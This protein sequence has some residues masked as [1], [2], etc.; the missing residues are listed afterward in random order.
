MADLN[1]IHPTLGKKVLQ[2]IDAVAKKGYGIKVAQGLR[3]LAEQSRLYAQGRT[4]KGKRVTNAP[5]GFSPHNYG[6]AVDFQLTVAVKEKGLLTHFPDKNPVWSI[7]GEEAK[8]A[9]L[10][11]G[12]SWKKFLDR[13]H[14]EIPILKYGRPLLK[15]VNGNDLSKVWKEAD[16]V[17]AGQIGSD[18]SDVLNQDDSPTFDYV[19][20][21]GD[22]LSA[23]AKKYLGDANRWIE[24]EKLNEFDKSGLPYTLAIGAKIKIPKK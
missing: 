22:S 13:P 4:T 23:I 14:V 16:R 24:I 5:A 12:G 19:V 11:W 9:G 18:S 20:K 2:I 15:L 17:F 7:I 3:S 6:C 8:K 10:E 21:A 1:L